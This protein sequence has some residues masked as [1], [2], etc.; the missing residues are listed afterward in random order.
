[1]APTLCWVDVETTGLDKKRDHLL[2]VAVVLT[3]DDL[4]E[5]AAISCPVKMG[6]RA[7]RRLE[8]YGEV[9]KMH[10]VNGL[11]AEAAHGAKPHIVDSFLVGFFTEHVRV[12]VN[13][14]YLG[15]NKGYT[16]PLAGSSVHFDRAFIERDLPG[17]AR[18]LHYRNV[19]V[20]TMYE[21]AK[22][23]LPEDA[24]PPKPNGSHRALADIRDSIA[25]LR[26]LR[27]A[28]GAGE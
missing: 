27:E 6:R 24:M 4:N 20:S 26:Q 18:H 16:L 7:R 9:H 13:R 15:G 5:V 1:M 17:F 10:L 25:L 14:L 28:F 19:D 3:D 12:P 11:K 2:E 21:L 23:W 22:R 8:R